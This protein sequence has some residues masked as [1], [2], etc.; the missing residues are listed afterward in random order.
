MNRLSR[1][2]SSSSLV[3]RSSS[4]P[5]IPQEAGVLNFED[6]ELSDVD[7]K[8][9]DWNVPKVPTSE[10]YKSSW[11]LKKVFKT[12]YHVG[13]KPLIRKGL[14]CSILIALRDSLYIRFNDSLLGTIESSLS[15]GPVHFNC[16]PDFIVHLHDQY[17]MKALTLNIKT[18]ETLTM[19]ETSQIALIY[20]VYYKCIRTNMNVQALDKRKMGET[21]LIQTTDVRSKIQVPR[22]LKWFEVSFPE[23]W[24]LK[25]ENYPLQIQN[26]AQNLDL[27]FVQQLA[28]GT[29]RLN[30]DQSRFRTPLD[31]PS[32][33]FKD[34]TVVE[35]VTQ[36]LEE[37]VK[38]EP[39]TPSH[40]KGPQ[41]AA[42]DIHTAS[43]SS[44]RTSSEN[45]KVMEHLENQFRGIPDGV[46]ALIYTI[47]KHFVGKPINI[48]SRIYDQ[49]SNLRCQ[50]LGDYQWYEDVFTT[51]VMH[52]SN[53]NSPFW[54]EKS[55]NGL[56]RIFGEKL[57]ETL[58]NTLGVIDYYNLTYGY[59][60]S[61]IRSEGMKMCRDFKI[62]SQA[63]KS[64]AKY[65]VGNFCTQY[66]LSPIAPSK[67]KSKIKGKESPEK[68][69]RKR[70]ASKY[71]RKQKYSNFK[72]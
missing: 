36:K 25:N 30:F 58:C 23:N 6:Y 53:Y 55:I 1:S 12:D 49:L 35:I 17:V 50:T 20:G 40:S 63:S 2:N 11:S 28:D 42:L 54:K 21:I 13:V 56:P 31:E 14:D 48:T 4:L 33:R 3:S 16:F 67:R 71:F 41:L 37:L 26:P 68:L 18:H 66:G 65:E 46:N 34:K 61:T 57:K 69:H 5:E 9:G 22:S 29:V 24:T 70:T 44:S 38:K 19:Q 8:I 43:S 7:L 32:L 72:Q 60:S 39:V 59:T 52:M 45:E 51:R 62:Q 27:D 15:G 10:I 64:K 47:M